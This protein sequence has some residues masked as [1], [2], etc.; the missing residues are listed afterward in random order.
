MFNQVLYRTTKSRMAM[1]FQGILLDSKTGR[2]WLTNAGH[3]FPGGAACAGAGRRRRRQ[4]EQGRAV[5][6]RGREPP[7]AVPRIE[8]SATTELAMAEGE[9]IVLYTD[10]LTEGRSPAGKMLGREKVR[11]TLI[12]VASSS[13]EEVQEKL[14]AD[15]MRF[16]AGAAQDDDITVVVVE[17][18]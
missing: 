9:K 3:P 5:H 8:L 13:A 15:A 12:E 14:I 17:A 11:R 6:P 2:V 18:A 16:Y 4:E 7:G 10:G 1:T